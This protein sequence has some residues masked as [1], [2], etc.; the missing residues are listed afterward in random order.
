MSKRMI[1]TN[2]I[3]AFLATYPM[4]IPL[5]HDLHVSDKNKLCALQWYEFGLKPN[6]SV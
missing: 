2:A 6:L 5:E 1:I 4:N 3:I